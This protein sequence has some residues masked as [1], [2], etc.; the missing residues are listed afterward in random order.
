MTFMLRER[1]DRNQ[2]LERLRKRPVLGAVTFPFHAG[3]WSNGRG[4]KY[5]PLRG[6][7]FAVGP[8]LS[9]RFYRSIAVDPS[10]IPLG[11]RVYIPAYR[12]DGYGGWF[13]AQDT[14]GAILGAHVDVYR[15]PPPTPQ[16]AGRY[17][18]EQRAFVVRPH[19]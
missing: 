12:H 16:E 14:G 7:S 18:I 17:L 3:G 4:R 10:V 2:R 19:R 9:L 11:S 15:P 5:V 1:I 6:V 13:I 8:A